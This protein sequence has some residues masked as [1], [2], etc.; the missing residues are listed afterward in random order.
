LFL[1]ICN[2]QERNGT[3]VVID[4]ASTIKFLLKWETNQKADW[5]IDHVLYAGIYDLSFSEVKPSLVPR[6][7]LA[8]FS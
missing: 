1:A 5:K 7:P 6:V 2:I 3:E 8:L 4:P